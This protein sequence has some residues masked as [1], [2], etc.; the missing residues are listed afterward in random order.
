M[1]S[2][3][4]GIS[5]SRSNLIDEDPT[6]SIRGGFPESVRVNTM[7]FQKFIEIG[8]MFSGQLPGLANVSL[9]D[10]HELNQVLFFKLSLCALQRPGAFSLPCSCAE[11]E[12]SSSVMISRKP[13]PRRFPHSFPVPSHFLANHGA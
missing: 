4:K 2:E 9:R 3:V 13:W 6:L 8:P 12:S 7:L 1:I 5:Y 10:L 11:R